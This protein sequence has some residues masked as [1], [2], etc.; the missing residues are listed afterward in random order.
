MFEDGAA[1]D[2]DDDDDI[3]KLL[4]TYPLQLHYGWW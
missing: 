2:D 3:T 1:A 4:R